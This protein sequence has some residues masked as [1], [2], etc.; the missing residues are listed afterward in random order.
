MSNRFVIAAYP[1]NSRTLGI[2]I[3]LYSGRD[4]YNVCYLDKIFNVKAGLV[5]DLNKYV[6]PGTEYMKTR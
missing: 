5:F 6:P 4:Y 2:F 1:A 3:S